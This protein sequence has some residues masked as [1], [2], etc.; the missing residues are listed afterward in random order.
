LAAAP[1]PSGTAFAAEAAAT[2]VAT[3]LAT[4]PEVLLLLADCPRE[5]SPRGVRLEGER[6]GPLGVLPSGFSLAGELSGSSFFTLS[7][8]LPCG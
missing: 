4:T 8:A 7:L 5:G 2:A 1:L 6:S 3:A